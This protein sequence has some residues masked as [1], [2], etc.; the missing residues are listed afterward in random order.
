[1]WC[2]LLLIRAIGSSANLSNCPLQRL[3]CSDVGTNF[4]TQTT[5]T[6]LDE[7]SNR[8]VAPILMCPEYSPILKF[9]KGFETLGRVVR[10]LVFLVY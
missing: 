3:F 8:P 10:W 5:F 9:S 2:A 4:N 1:M 6:G 7:C